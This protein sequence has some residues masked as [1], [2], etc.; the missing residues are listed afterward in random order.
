[1]NSAS[2]RNEMKGGGETK[3]SKH[4]FFFGAKVFSFF[5]FFFLD[6]SIVS[7][8]FSAAN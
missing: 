6:R 2:V 7:Y 1:M 8:S 3:E 4:L 5:F